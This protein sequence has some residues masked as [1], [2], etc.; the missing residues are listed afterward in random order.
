MD[1]EKLKVTRTNLKS[2]EYDGADIMTAWLAID[3]LIGLH[4]EPTLKH[5]QPTLSQSVDERAELFK[6]HVKCDNSCMYHCT[7]GFT[8]RAK[9]ID[10]EV[11]SKPQPTSQDTATLAIAL[12]ALA[13]AD[14]H[15]NSE[16]IKR[17]IASVQKAIN[18]QRAT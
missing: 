7:E 14:G 3:E 1:I 2:G 17:A 9:C 13:W 18:E 16:L 11:N 4:A 6:P 5:E 10:S 8:I 15:L 12:E